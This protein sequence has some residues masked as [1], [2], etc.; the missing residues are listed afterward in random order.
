M[1]CVSMQIALLS[2]EHWTHSRLSQS[3]FSYAILSNA[4]LPNWASTSA[5]L[6]NTTINTWLCCQQE[7]R[8][9]ILFLTVILLSRLV[10]LWSVPHSIQPK[11]NNKGTV[12]VHSSHTYTT[13]DSFCLHPSLERHEAI[14]GQISAV[15]FGNQHHISRVLKHKL[16]FWRLNNCNNPPTKSHGLA[17]G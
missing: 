8:L 14:L 9:P 13:P 12:V 7:K 2:T 16:L 1:S 11:D 15:V 4:G 5:R 3:P 6:S 10:C 17:N